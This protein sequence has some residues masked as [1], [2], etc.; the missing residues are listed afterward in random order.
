M[1]ALDTYVAHEMVH[2]SE[3]TG[4]YTAQDAKEHARG[5]VGYVSGTEYSPH[6]AQVPSSDHSRERYVGVH[7]W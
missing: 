7:T 2:G 1:T 5:Y 3:A 4:S 6:V